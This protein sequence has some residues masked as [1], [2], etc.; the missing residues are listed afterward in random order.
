M[1]LNKTTVQNSDG[2]SLHIHRLDEGRLNELL[3]GAVTLEENE[4]EVI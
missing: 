4:T 1:L 3:H 2:E